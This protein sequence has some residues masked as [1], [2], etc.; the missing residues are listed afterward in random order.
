VSLALRKALTKSNITSGCRGVGILPLN[1][2]A[3]DRYLLPSKTYRDEA[4]GGD[5]PS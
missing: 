4:G 5:F 1:S 3:V 2:H